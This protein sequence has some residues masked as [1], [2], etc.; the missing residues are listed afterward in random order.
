MHTLTV[1]YRI[2]HTQGDSSPWILSRMFGVHAHTHNAW[3]AFIALY[4]ESCCH[5][6][7]TRS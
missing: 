4:S 3:G 1:K 7:K 6:L 5:A 2:K